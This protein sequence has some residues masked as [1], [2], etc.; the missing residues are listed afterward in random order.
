MTTVA[1]EDYD[2]LV[3]RIYDAALRPEC[4]QEVLERI[5]ALLD[6][7][8][9]NL[10]SWT[11]QPQQ[12]GFFFTTFPGEVV[13]RYQRIQ[14]DDPHMKAAAHK[15]LFAEGTVVTSDD[16]VKE[17][18]LFQSC[19][20]QQIWQPL[21]IRRMCG[22]T[23]FGASDTHHL[24]TVVSV[25]RL[26]D[27]PRFSPADVDV[28][29]RL[30]AHLSR[31]LG[32]M[33]HLRD[34]DLQLAATRASLD[35]LTTAIVLFSAD[36]SVEFSNRSAAALAE[37][38]RVIRMRAGGPG[39]RTWLDLAGPGSRQ[40][41]SLQRR[42]A[43]ALRPIVS[44]YE[45]SFANAVIVKGAHGEPL[46]VI[47]VAPLPITHRFSGDL[48]ESH[49][50]AFIYDLKAAATVDPELLIQAFDLSPAEARVALD[51][52]NGGDIAEM[53]RRLGRS[54]NTVKTQ[55]QQVFNK[56]Q[57]RRRS[58]LLKVILSFAGSA[59][60]SPSERTAA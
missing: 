39:G 34:A 22:G 1:L 29:S 15:Q 23:V 53:A 57:V 38:G 20:Y 56:T 14:H 42:I 26:D 7:P 47:H 10:F 4:M 9:G 27:A 35:R 46:A 5:C 37:E 31:A 32:V 8:F 40:Q 58:D 51:T 52:L 33:Y 44:D 59:G 25:H 2:N 41:A 43:D 50:I 24:P 11:R 17:S 21:R 49:A 3:H 36:G 48:P 30:L 55:L 16:L 28:V 45:G 18:E 12:G 60:V 54:P 6:A 19:V 13:E